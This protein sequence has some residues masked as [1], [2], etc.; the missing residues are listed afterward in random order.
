MKCYQLFQYFA[1]VYVAINIIPFC[2]VPVFGSYLLAFDAIC[3]TEFWL[4][5][6]FPLPFCVKWAMLLFKRWRERTS[7]GYVAVSSEFEA[8][9]GVESCN[10]DNVETPRSAV[11]QILLGPFRSHS[12]FLCFP[13][14]P[15]PW[16]GFLI[17]RRLIIILPFTFVYNVNMRMSLALA[18]C[19]IILVIILCGFTHV[20]A[21]YQGGYV[22]TLNLYPLNV[23]N[24][25]E[26]ILIF[27]PLLASF[28][29]IFYAILYVFLVWF[30]RFIEYY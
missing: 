9:L 10:G 22:E 18:T 26:T 17:F 15:I 24:I 6:L 4:G 25:M 11:L 29:V 28:F 12:S 7:Q 3:L 21:Y 30:S 16:E 5:C 2:L 23:I 14:S 13:E 8:V 19:V 20:K 1:F 27:I